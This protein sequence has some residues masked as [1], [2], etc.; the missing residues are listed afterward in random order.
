MVKSAQLNHSGRERSTL[1]ITPLGGLGEFGLNMMAFRMG[2]S[3]MLVDAGLMFPSHESPGVNLILPD[4]SYLDAHRSIFKGVVLTHGHEDHIGA[5]PYLLRNHAVPVYGTKL[6]L[7]ICRRRLEEHGLLGSV[8]LTEIAPGERFAIGEFHIEFV[9]VA[10]SLAD[11]VAVAIETPYGVVVHTGDFKVDEAPPVG[12][13]IDLQRFAELGR[14][15]VLCLLSDS[16]NSEVAGSTGAESS[17]AP[18]F[19][20][21]FE[22][23]KGRVLLTCFTSNTHR[24]QTAIDVALKHRRKI[25]LVGRSMVNN[26]RLAIDLGYLRAPEDVFCRIE[27][28]DQVPRG[29]QLVIVAGSQGEPM[30]ALTQVAVGNHRFLTVEPGD[31]VILSTRVIPGNEKAVNRTINE[32]FRRGAEVIRPPEA[33][34]H[35]SGHGSAED[36]STMLGLIKPRYFVPI[37]GESR[38]LYQHARIARHSGNVSDRV[39]LAEDGNVLELDAEGASVSGNVETGQIFIDGNG[40]GPVDEC[41]VRDRRRLG[42]G[43]VIVPVVTLSSSSEPDVSDILSRGF[44]DNDDANGVLA[45]ARDA[46]LAAIRGVDSNERRS[47]AM[48]KELVEKALKRFFRKRGMRRPAILPVV[49]GPE[50]T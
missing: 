10:H 8:E 25:T 50:R 11:A 34:V 47:E 31:V 35:V 42:V 29:D 40:L 45:D 19:D 12:P 6:T 27:D 36:L 33:K 26:V 41:I 16:T 43:G 17:V 30:S 1:Q 49:L 3:L 22:E 23:T 39:F 38:Q 48:I 2:D 9:H 37:H 14:K 13:P 4:T 24:I 46:M 32:L 20:K 18:A 21:I 5:L 15:G 28:L 44:N 7:A